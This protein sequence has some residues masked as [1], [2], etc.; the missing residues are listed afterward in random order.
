MYWNV[1]DNARGAWDIVESDD[2]PYSDF[3]GALGPWYSR[4]PAK[5]I[6]GDIPNA[7]TYSIAFA[8]KRARDNAN[9]QKNG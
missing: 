7:S 1:Y 2:K 5:M 9:R 3:P 6:K 4:L 8:E